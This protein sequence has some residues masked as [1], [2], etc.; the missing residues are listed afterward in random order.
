MVRRFRQRRQQVISSERPTTTD[1]AQN[2]AVIV[3]G[4]LR[5][6][7]GQRIQIDFFLRVQLERRGIDSFVSK[8]LLWLC[9]CVCPEHVVFVLVSLFVHGRVAVSKSRFVFSLV[10][11]SELEYRKVF[12]VRVSF[13]EISFHFSLSFN[14][15]VYFPVI[16][17]LN[18][19]SNF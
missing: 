16:L 1:G 10:S 17:V 2:S 12:W 11:P 6:R 5:D 18:F 9:S 7:I 4:L 19:P 15:V 13:G 3:S 14:L 8:N